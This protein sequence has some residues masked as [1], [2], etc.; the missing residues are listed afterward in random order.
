[1]TELTAQKV[2]PSEICRDWQVKGVRFRAFI[3]V[4][5]R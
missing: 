5:A 4:V 1:M 3:Q 2:D